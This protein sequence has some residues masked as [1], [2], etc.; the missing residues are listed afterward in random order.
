[1][2]LTASLILVSI[3]HKAN[4][5]LELI[6]TAMKLFR[7][8]NTDILVDLNSP[9]CLLVS[10]IKIKVQLGVSG[11]ESVTICREGGPASCRGR[12]FFDQDKN[13]ANSV[14]GSIS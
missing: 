11:R 7:K 2:S 3:F 8:R 1:M 14:V 9:C 12:D 10:S 13:D 4:R 6:Q 5:G